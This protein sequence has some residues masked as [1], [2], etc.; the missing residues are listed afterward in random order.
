LAFTARRYDEARQIYRKLLD[1]SGLSQDDRTRYLAQLERLKQFSVVAAHVGSVQRQDISTLSQDQIQALKTAFGKLYQDNTNNGYKFIA[2]IYSRYAPLQQPG[3][4]VLFLAWHRAYLANF[5]A[6]LRRLNPSLSVPYW[7]WTRSASLPA[8]VQGSDVDN[9]LA[10][11]PFALVAADG[12]VQQQRPTVRQVSPTAP[13]TLPSGLDNALLELPDLNS[14]GGQLQNYHNIIHVLVGGDMATVT[15]AAY[16]PLFWFLTAN[17]D[18]LWSLW[19]ARHGGTKIADSILD[20][21]LEPFDK[22]VRDVLDTE[23]LGYRY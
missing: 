22:T 10:S 23:K 4:E 12:N 18:R 1:T 13:N 14:F 9:S 2:G 16:D 11:G 17:V 6:A 19:Q 15:G 3:K 5:E 8:A 7:D 21:K 20:Q